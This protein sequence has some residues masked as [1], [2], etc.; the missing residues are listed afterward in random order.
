MNN[1][2]Q[3]IHF[4]LRLRTFRWWLLACFIAVPLGT[5]LNRTIAIAFFSILLSDPP[6]YGAISRLWIVDFAH[7][8]YTRLGGHLAVDG[9]VL[10][11]CQ[12]LVLRRYFYRASGWLV[13]TAIGSAI[14]ILIYPFAEAGIVAL[15]NTYAWLYELP[16]L[17]EFSYSFLP[18]VLGLGLGLG[19]AQ[20]L[21]LRSHFKQAERWIGAVFLTQLLI[22]I[23][24]E[25][26]LF[27]Q[28]DPFM[29]T[30]LTGQAP[31]PLSIFSLVFLGSCKFLLTGLLQG[32]LTGWVLAGFVAQQKRESVSVF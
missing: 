4:T 20:Y 21:F 17:K 26:A 11:F 7:N 16:M 22:E 24:N 28:P 23:V 15:H 9:L 29:N 12:W 25:S 6:I 3:S 8:Y 2:L 1:F 13:A 27:T 19:I 32:A 5:L 31:A 10:G 30:L 14:A 18:S